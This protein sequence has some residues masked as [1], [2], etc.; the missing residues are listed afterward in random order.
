[1]R[2]SETWD[3][4]RTRES[5]AGSQ[6]D[7]KLSSKG[8]VIM[9]SEL[10]DTI[11]ITCYSKPQVKYEEQRMTGVCPGVFHF[12]ISISRQKGN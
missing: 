9:A 5:L 4:G 2:V 11:P 7:D 6:A 12:I 10:N 3:P 1:M 8:K